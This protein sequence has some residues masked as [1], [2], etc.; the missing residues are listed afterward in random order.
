MSE[1]KYGVLENLAINSIEKRNNKKLVVALGLI[2]LALGIISIYGNLEGAHALMLNGLCVIS[3][4]LAG[5][6]AMVRDGGNLRDRD[7]LVAISQFKEFFGKHFGR[8][9]SEWIIQPLSEMH[10][11]EAFNYLELILYGESRNHALS[12]PTLFDRMVSSELKGEKFN[13]Q[14]IIHYM[15]SLDESIK[16]EEEYLRLIGKYEKINE[17]ISEYRSRMSIVIGITQS[18]L[19]FDEIKNSENLLDYL[20]KLSETSGLSDNSLFETFADKVFRFREFNENW[21]K[22]ELNSIHQMF[23][24]ISQYYLENKDIQ[25]TSTDEQKQLLRDYVKYF[26]NLEQE[27]RISRLKI[28]DNTD[29]EGD[30][31]GNSDLN[32]MDLES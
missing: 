10:N 6:A 1:K 22:V 32:L 8:A 25:H 29:Q 9:G 7:N 18:E 5:W 17:V 23:Y 28:S 26:E 30:L 24:I 31:R 15:N 13:T 14:I 16:R 27:D 4:L 19:D 2:T 20:G 12:E 3:F 11:A 21:A